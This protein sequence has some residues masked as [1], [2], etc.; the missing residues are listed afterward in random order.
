MQRI[1][2]I[3]LYGAIAGFDGPIRVEQVQGVGVLASGNQVYRQFP[4]VYVPPLNADA[5]VPLRG[6]RRERANPWPDQ[7]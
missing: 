6:Q 1:L 7:S 3:V 2:L 4:P 5:P